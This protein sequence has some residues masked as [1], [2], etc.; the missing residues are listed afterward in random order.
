MDGYELTA[1]LRGKLPNIRLI[2][3][4]RENRRGMR[5]RKRRNPPEQEAGFFRSG[6]RI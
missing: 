1:A 4:S 6:G 5:L 3:L 2:A